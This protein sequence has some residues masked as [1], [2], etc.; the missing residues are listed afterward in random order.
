MTS[1]LWKSPSAV[2]DTVQIW[3]HQPCG[4]NYFQSSN[5]L[6]APCDRDPVVPNL[7]VRREAQLARMG[8][9]TQSH[10]AGKSRAGMWA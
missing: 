9:L 4:K 7:I 8:T 6:K 10:T 1:A 3:H 5:P 2:E